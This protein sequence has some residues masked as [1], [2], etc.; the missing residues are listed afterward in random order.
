[1]TEG[2]LQARS[3]VRARTGVGNRTTQEWFACTEEL[4]GVMK[5]SYVEVA[6]AS[7][8]RTQ[9]KRVGELSARFLY[10]FRFHHQGISLR[11]M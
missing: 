7:A 2:S 1:M 8:V 11:C 6:T 10:W 9:A 4:I 5:K 3:S